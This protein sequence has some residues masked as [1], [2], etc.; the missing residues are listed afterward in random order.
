VGSYGFQTSFRPHM[1]FPRQLAESG[2]NTAA[3]GKVLHL[4]SNDRSIWN[5]DSWEN[6]W[7]DYQSKE[8]EFQNSSTMPDR[9]KKE[10]DFR[11]YLFTSRAIQAVKTLN[12]QDKNWMVYLIPVLNSTT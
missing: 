9:Y 12:A 5:F 8:V 7:Y 3:F 11:D 6:N 2:Y 4:E 1:I 10:E